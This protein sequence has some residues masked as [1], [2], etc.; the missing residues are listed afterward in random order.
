MASP[1]GGTARTEANGAEGPGAAGTGAAA[2]GRMA[3]GAAGARGPVAVR[4][5][6]GSGV[7]SARA[8]VGW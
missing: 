5:T 7:W 3:A 8:C 4:S 1:G 6:R 2:A